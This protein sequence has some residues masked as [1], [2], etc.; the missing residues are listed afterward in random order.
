MS[1]SSLVTYT[2]ISPNKTVMSA[3]VN[4]KITIHHMAANWTV[5]RC[6][7]EF[8]KTSRKASANYGVDGQGH[9]GLYVDESDRSWASS[10]R[11]NDEQAVTIEVAND[12]TTTWH[13][14]DVALYKT[15]ELCVD[16]CRRNHIDKLIWTGKSNGNLTVH[17]MFA[18]TACPGDYLYSKMPFIADE[19]NKQLNASKSGW[20]QD[21]QGW[22]YVYE[23]GSYPKACWMTIDEHQYYFHDSGYMAA[24]EWVKSAEYDSNHKLYYLN[25]DGIWDNNTYYWKSNAKG[26][27]LTD[28]AESW[29]PTSQWLKI[30]TRR[31][32][33]D[34]DGYMVTGNAI[35]ED[36]GYNFADDGHLIED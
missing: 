31:Y 17:R 24:D 10:S 1:N 18:A 36:K 3:K 7:Q 16:I 25:K 22:W 15:I 19:V 27:W 6:G 32:Y 29:Y 35:I 28:S 2:L 9:V 4:R 13:V 33:F 34:S 11:A 12:N 23:D 5:E 14:S 8:Q 21:N 20:Q 30:D 26:W